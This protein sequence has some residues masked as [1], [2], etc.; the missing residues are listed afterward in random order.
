MDSFRLE[1]DHKIYKIIPTVTGLHTLYSVFTYSSFHTI[2]K[3][4]ADKWEVIE[5]RFG[6]YHLPLL[7]IGKGIDEHF[8]KQR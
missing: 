1:V 3:T 6:D 5:H 7:Q 4:I 8:N 2:I